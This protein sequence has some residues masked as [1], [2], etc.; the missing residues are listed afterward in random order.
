VQVGDLVIMPGSWIRNMGETPAVGVVVRE[1]VNLGKTPTSARVAIL[2][3]DGDGTPDMEPVH[4][5]EVIS[6]SR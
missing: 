3:A 6:E 1:P 4:W 5:L 2:W